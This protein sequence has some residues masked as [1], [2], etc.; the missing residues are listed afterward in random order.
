MRETRLPQIYN[1]MQFSQD[2]SLSGTSL[3]P[4]PKSWIQGAAQIA[5]GLMDASGSPC[6]AGPVAQ[7]HQII[8][9]AS[10][11]AGLPDIPALPLPRT[12]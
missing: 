10:M 4:T 9:R 11:Q 12:G 8:Q 1:V 2:S 5:G 6:P 3:K 7:P